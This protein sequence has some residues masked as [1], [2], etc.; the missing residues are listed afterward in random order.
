MISPTESWRWVR[1]RAAV[2]LL[3]LAFSGCPIT[4][5]YTRPEV[6]LPASWGESNDARLAN[7]A[8]N[9]AWWKSFND[10]ALDQ[11]VELAYQQNLPLQETGLRILE[12]RAQ[13]GIARAQQYPNGGSAF[14]GAGLIGVHSHQDPAPDLTINAGTFPVGFDVSWEVDIW[15]KFR[16]GVR[17]A[18][19]TFYATV[20]GYDD[21]VVSLTAEVARTYTLI[22][23][24]QVFIELARQNVA[25]QEEGLHIA[26]SRFRNGAT[27]ELDVSQARTLLEST[28]A[29]IPEFQVNL[30]QGE[31]ALCTLL[32]RAPGCAAPLLTGPAVI[33]TP[34]GQV[35][36]SVPAD[37]LRRRPDIRGAELKA[38]AQGDR[39]GVART[40]LFPKFVLS[41]AIVS[42]NVTTSGAPAVVS[43][44]S[45][46]FNAGSFL[47]SVAANL[48]WPILAYPQIISNVRVQDARLQQSLVDY[49]QTV[50][51]AAQEVQDGIVGFLRE[52]E[53]ATFEQNAVTAAQTSVRISV[54]QYRE[55]AVDYQR[56]LDSQR[57][58]LTAQIALARMRSS[59]VTNL[60]ALYKGLGGGWEVRQG[61]PV[62]R[63]DVRVEMQ[64]RTNWGGYLAPPQSHPAPGSAPTHR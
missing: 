9:V 16:R 52:Q 64:K 22:R 24:Y 60:I 63:D 12:A 56:V 23:T 55:G 58:L 62:V 54:L 41:G 40:D 37:L 47:Y 29:S 7:T 35:A 20:A 3:L 1:P 32:G 33:P 6:P 28:R 38:I 53:A 36:V 51:K 46:L 17:A 27:S 14:A 4:P 50:L 18:R 15:G 45:N 10:P 26:E 2:G 25:V 11:L 5:K 13:L 31:N 49:K 19:A 57:E 43:M 48:L 8:I 44:L 39:V 30:Q 42:E 61:Q 59:I 21:A 34:P